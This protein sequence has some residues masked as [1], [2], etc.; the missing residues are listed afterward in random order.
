MAAG[1]TSDTFKT[2]KPQ[3]EAAREFA[4]RGSAG[5]GKSGLPPAGS[6]RFT[7]NMR[8]DLHLR[9]KIA[10]AKERRT[11]AE[12]IEALVEQHVKA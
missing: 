2:K 4:E 8:E 5:Q 6:V 10:A 1:K 7:M 3:L 9:L 12:M 11:M